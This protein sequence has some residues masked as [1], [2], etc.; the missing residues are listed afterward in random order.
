M[1]AHAA[2]YAEN[3]YLDSESRTYVEETGGANVLFVAKDGTLVVPKSHTDSILP[4]ITRRSLVQV[5]QDLEIA[6]DERPVTWDEVA[7][8][9][10]VECGLCG[11]AAVISPVGEI[12]DDDTAVVFPDGHESSG[13]VMKRLRETL[14]GIQGGQIE[15][16]HGWVCKIC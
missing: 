9:A 4:S 13:P 5:A 7:S 8:G 6:V 14:T 1:E 2:G 10:F 16:T 12:H 3:L 11:T 15:D